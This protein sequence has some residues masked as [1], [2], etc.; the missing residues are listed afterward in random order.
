M[1]SATFGALSREQLG[2]DLVDV[3]L[4]PVDGRPVVVD[5]RVQDRVKGRAGPW[6]SSSGSASSA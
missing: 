4:E 3:V 6:R 1:R 5:H 2:L